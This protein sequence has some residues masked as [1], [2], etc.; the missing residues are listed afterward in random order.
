MDELATALGL[1]DNAARAQL[2]GP[3]R[4][5]LVRQRELRSTGG[6]PSYFLVLVE[7]TGACF[8]IRGCSCP[9]A[10]EEAN[11]DGFLL[12]EAC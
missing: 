7:E 8:V 4:D 5:G 10:V 9:L 3:E 2:A 6:R 1:M 12:A 11:P